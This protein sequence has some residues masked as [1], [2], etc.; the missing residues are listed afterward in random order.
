MKTQPAQ[1]APKAKQGSRHHARSREA[2]IKDSRQG[3]RHYQKGGQ[4]SPRAAGTRAAEQAA[5]RDQEA[6]QGTAR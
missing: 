5:E 1:P 6:E 2:G 3:N 4:Q